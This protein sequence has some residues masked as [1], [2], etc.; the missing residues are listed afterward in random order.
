MSDSTRILMGVCAG[1]LAG[2]VVAFALF[3][4]RGRGAVAQLNATLDEASRTL[5]GFRRALRKAEGV[6]HE[7]RRAVEDVRTVLAGEPLAEV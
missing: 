2:S 1:A 5:R 4:P 3:T 6:A 7:T